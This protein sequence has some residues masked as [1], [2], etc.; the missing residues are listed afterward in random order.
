MKLNTETSRLL[1]QGNTGGSID[2]LLNN[3]SIKN[4]KRFSLIYS[5]KQKIKVKAFV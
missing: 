2:V 3:S 1:E 4:G 5:Y